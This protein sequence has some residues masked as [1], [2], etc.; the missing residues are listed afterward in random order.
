MENNTQGPVTNCLTFNYWNGFAEHYN[1][2]KKKCVSSAFFVFC[3]SSPDWF[4]VLN[5][6]GIVAH[7]A[8]AYL[9]RFFHDQLPTVLR[10]VENITLALGKIT[11]ENQQFK[12]EHYSQRTGKYEFYMCFTNLQTLEKNNLQFDPTY[13]LRLPWAMTGRTWSVFVQ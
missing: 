5:P 10:I 13:V 6:L 12:F 9:C 11:A 8:I 1:I 2:K 7:E 4:I 3:P